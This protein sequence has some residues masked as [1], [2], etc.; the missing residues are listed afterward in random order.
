MN[1]FGQ[2]LQI[3]T[4]INSYTWIGDRIYSRGG[5]HWW[6]HPIVG[7]DKC[8]YWPPRD[9]N[10]VLK[11]DPETQ[12]LPSLMGDDLGEGHIYKWLHGALATDGAI[13]C[14][15]SAEANQIL[16]I[17][18]FKE[19]AM[20]MQNNIPT[21]PEELG[22]LFAKDG[23]NETFYNSAVR[24]FGIDKVFKFLVEECLPSDGEWA[25]NFSGNLPL[26]MIAAS[27]EISAVSVIYHLLRRNVHDAL[28]GN[29]DGSVRSA[30]VV[31]LDCCGVSN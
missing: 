3:D 21:Y 16:V 6:G 1:S 5:C 4:T 7:V 13:Y 2:V 31:A 20:T 14:L 24:K 17:D 22:R 25:D 18:P 28:S 26:F 29:N 23:C 30:S 10:R 11:F 8:I 27:C 19:L 9:A 12:H 15:P